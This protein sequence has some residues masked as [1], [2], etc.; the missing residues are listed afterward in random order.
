MSDNACIYSAGNL[1]G[2]LLSQVKCLWPA[3]LNNRRG[4]Q[5][6][7][8]GRISTFL[9]P[10]VKTCI[11]DLIF[12]GEM[13]FWCAHLP[14][15]RHIIE[16]AVSFFKILF[17]PL[18]LLMVFPIIGICFLFSKCYFNFSLLPVLYTLGPQFVLNMLV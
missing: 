12:C 14:I 6:V 2:C 9:T 10:K 5:T 16:T 3:F 8:P 7:V 13:E 18:L 4:S 15:T 11:S 1:S 17:F